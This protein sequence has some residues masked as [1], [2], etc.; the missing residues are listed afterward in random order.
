[1]ETEKGACGKGVELE[2]LEGVS[3]EK[4]VFFFVE[5]GV[6]WEWCTYSSEWFVVLWQNV[7]YHR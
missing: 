5:E 7:R 3:T 1:M 4:L 6:R 2:L